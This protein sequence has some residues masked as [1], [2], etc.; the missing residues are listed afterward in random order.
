[1]TSFD[2]ARQ[3]PAPGLNRLEVKRDEL[4]SGK[5]KGSRISRTIA[6]SLLR[7]QTNEFKLNTDA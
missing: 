5:E 3:P 4:S 6:N 2:P 7:R 1:M